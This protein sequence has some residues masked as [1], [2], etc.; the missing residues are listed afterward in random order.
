MVH[1]RPSD[2]TLKVA[3]KRAGPAEVE[4]I[5]VAHPLVNEA[6]VIGV[7]DEVKGTAMVAFCVLTGPQASRLHTP[8]TTSKKQASRMRSQSELRLLV[9]KDMGKSL[10]RRGYISS[11][12]CQKPATPK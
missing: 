2:D 12:P 1:P 6:A 10:T 8:Q 7:P 5:L 3:G 9:A 4:S 11:L